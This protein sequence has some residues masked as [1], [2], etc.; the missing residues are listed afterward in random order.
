M[1]GYKNYEGNP[2]PGALREQI[3]IVREEN[4][5]N[6]NGYPETVNI[7][8]YTKLWASADDAGNQK[9]RAGDSEIAQ[10]VINFTIRHRPGIEPGMFVLF[11]GLRREIVDIGHYGFRSRYLGLKTLQNQGVTQ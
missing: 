11:E 4:T 1:R 3:D 10:N 8:V 7:P 9:F 2:H 6:A 5:V